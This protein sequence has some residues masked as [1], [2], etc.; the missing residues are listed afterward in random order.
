MTEG[1]NFII[2]DTLLLKSM[3]QTFFKRLQVMS[4][5]YL[6][7]LRKYISQSG[8]YISSLGRRESGYEA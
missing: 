3:K 2:L 6:E 5:S 7:G 1:L 8:I 4:F